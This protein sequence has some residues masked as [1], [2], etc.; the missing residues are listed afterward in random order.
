MAALAFSRSESVDVLETFR[1]ASFFSGNFGTLKAHG[2]F[3]GGQIGY[4]WQFVLGSR[5]TSKALT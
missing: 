2:P 1:G 4:N 5:P 3:G